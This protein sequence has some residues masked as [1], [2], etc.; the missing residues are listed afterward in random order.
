MTW[1]RTAIAGLLFLVAVSRS[2]QPRRRPTTSGCSCHRRSSSGRVRPLLVAGLVEIQRLGNDGALAGLTAGYYALA[3]LGFAL[4]Y[5]LAEAAHLASY[6]I[7]LT[8]AA[9]LALGTAGLV[10]RRSARLAEQTIEEPQL[11]EAA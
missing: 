7:L 3:Y 9:V 11:K 2:A 5:L 4:P 6:T 8:I 1:H 10:T